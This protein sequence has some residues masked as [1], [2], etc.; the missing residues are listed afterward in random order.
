MEQPARRVHGR[1]IR[2]TLYGEVTRASVWLRW[3]LIFV[4]TI[5]FYVDRPEVVHVVWVLLGAAAYNVVLTVLLRVSRHPPL[6]AVSV[7]DLLTLV[8]LLALR[9]EAGGEAFIIFGF[10]VLVLTLAYGWAGVA[11]SMGAYAIGESAVSLIQP[12]AQLD[13]ETVIVR[14]GFLIVL[15]V[16][17]GALVERYEGLRERLA[18]VSIHDRV[19]G[20]YNRHYFAEVLEQIHKL[21]IRGGSTYSVLVIDI[22]GLDIINK[23]E[24]WTA[25]DRLLRTIGVEARAA[26]RSTDLLGR[27]G[28]DAF[29]MA[30]PETGVRA[31]EKVAEKLQDRL[32]AVAAGLGITIGVAEVTPTW[33]NG[34]DDGLRAAFAAVERAKP[35]GDSEVAV[36][37]VTRAHAEDDR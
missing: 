4:G 15:S 18:R 6:A 13:F 3:L 35:V 36:I 9:S 14:A 23:E 29:G 11:L 26:L 20:L 27:V 33:D 37:T 17:L 12:E 25:G 5:W 24:G 21:A 19:T 28:E 22:G 7:L 1:S 34:F 16:V 31:A 8:S 2:T 30:L 10:L 32:R